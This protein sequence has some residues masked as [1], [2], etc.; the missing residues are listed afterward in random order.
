MYTIPNGFRM[1][2]FRM[3]WGTTPKAKIGFHFARAHVPVFE[4]RRTDVGGGSSGS[5]SFDWRTRSYSQYM[6]KFNVYMDSEYVSGV[7]MG[8]NGV[9]SPLFGSTNRITKSA[10][11]SLSS[12]I[13]FISVTSKQA[14][15]GFVISDFFSNN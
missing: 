12:Y 8:L 11:F 3:G 4:L 15:H 9:Q 10:T 2:G 14:I 6:L 13:D 7:Q 5:Q 1:Y